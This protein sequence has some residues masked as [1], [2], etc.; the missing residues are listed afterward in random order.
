MFHNVFPY[1]TFLPY[2]PQIFKNVPP[3]ISTFLFSFQRYFF[4]RLKKIIITTISKTEKKYKLEL[5]I[6]KKKNN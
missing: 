3:Q 5:I 1:I 4:F 6:K 2:F